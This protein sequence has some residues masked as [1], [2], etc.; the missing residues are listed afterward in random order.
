MK[1]QDANRL[2]SSSEVILHWLILK[3]VLLDPNKVLIM[4]LVLDQLIMD[5]TL[6]VLVIIISGLLGLVLLLVEV[7]ENAR[8]SDGQRAE[9]N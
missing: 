4:L 1:L 5:N 9:S 8:G 2:G 6:I 3:V 7:G